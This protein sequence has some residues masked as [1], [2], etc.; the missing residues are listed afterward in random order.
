[1][2]EKLKLTILSFA[3]CN[4]NLARF[5]KEYIERLKEATGKLQI[6]AEIDLVHATEAGMSKQYGWM[7]DIFPLFLKYGAAVTPALFVG[8]KLELYGGVPTTEKLVEVILKHVG[9]KG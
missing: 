4:P 6:E 7:S 1:M 2:N 5:D 3:C 9:S 8:Q